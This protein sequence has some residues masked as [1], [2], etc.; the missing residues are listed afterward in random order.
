MKCKCPEC[1]CEFEQD[2]IHRVVSYSTENY[3]SIDVP[4]VDYTGVKLPTG[5]LHTIPT[6]Y[7]PYNHVW[8]T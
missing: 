8:C 7:T 4:V 1:N 3:I 6:G 2:L 5:V